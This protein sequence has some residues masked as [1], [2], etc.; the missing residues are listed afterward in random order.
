MQR[1][2]THAPGRFWPCNECHDEPRHIVT[3]GRTKKETMQF[4]VP[5]ERHSLECGC[6]RCTGRHVSLAAAEGEWG[7]RYGQ[8]PL[9]LPAPVVTMRR[10]SRSK[11]AAH[12]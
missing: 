9:A 10:T 1:H 7:Q 6:G 12:A 8:L 4:D 11:G 2:K 3:T 5:T